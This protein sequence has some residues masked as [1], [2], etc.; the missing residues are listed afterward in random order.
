MSLPRPLRHDQRRPEDIERGQTLSGPLTAAEREAAALIVYPANV[1]RPRTR[2]ECQGGE[3]PCPFVSCRFHL[4]L[5]VQ[6]PAVKLNFP[7]REVDE[8][9]ET[10]ALDVADRGGATLHEAG[11]LMNVTRERVR[12]IELT[13]ARRAGKRDEIEDWSDRP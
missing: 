3:R 10:C 13:A 4:Y 12:Q 2:G 5:D 8:L 1:D 9:D 11:T 6:G 7:D